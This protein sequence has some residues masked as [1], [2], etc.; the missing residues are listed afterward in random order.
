M[1]RV[2][3]TALL[4][5]IIAA[6]GFLTL[7]VGSLN[8]FAASSATPTHVTAAA[9]IPQT[10]SKPHKHEH[11]D[12]SPEHVAQEHGT[13]TVVFFDKQTKGEP[14]PTGQKVCFSVTPKNAGEVG[15]GHTHCAYIGAHNRATDTF[16]A[17]GK[18]CGRVTI[19]ATE[20]GE[21]ETQ[22]HHTVIRIVCIDK[23]ATTTAAMLPAGSPLPPSGGSWLLGAMGVSAA[24]GSG[25]AMRNRR[26]F[27]PGRLA[28][29]QSA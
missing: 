18:V 1:M 10:S 12:C 28:A 9:A 11:V 16:T 14:N 25:F 29:N 7:T 4:A 26:W 22:A 20:K 23:H 6:G 15:S 27:S 19:T 17:S 3:R 2:A 8:V 24:L 21:N 13:C 5:P